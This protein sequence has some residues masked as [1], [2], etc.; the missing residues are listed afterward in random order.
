MKVKFFPCSI[1][2]LSFLVYSGAGV[3]ETVTVPNTFSVGQILESSKL[4][5]NFSELA[6]GINEN[7][8]EVETNTKNITT[9][10]EKVE[11]KVD[12]SNYTLQQKGVEIYDKNKKTVDIGTHTDKSGKI[13]TYNQAGKALIDLE[14]D[15]ENGSGQIVVRDALGRAA[16]RMRSLAH[17]EEDHTHEESASRGLIEVLNTNTEEVA[18]DI[19]M[20]S[21]D[22]GRIATLNTLGNE[23]VVVGAIVGSGS[24]GVHVSDRYG[25]E[26]TQIFARPTN[27]NDPE[28][29]SIGVINVMN[30]RT[31]VVETQTYI[32]GNSIGSSVK[33]FIEPHPL[34]DS[35]NI[36]YAAIEGP[37]AAMYIRGTATLSEGYA[38][39]DL[40]EH[41]YLLASEQGM[42]AKM[43]PRSLDS[44]G[45]ALIDLTPQTLEV[46][47]LNSGKGNYTF[48]YI[49]YAVR[50]RYEDYV[51]VRDK[52]QGG[53]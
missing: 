50:K 31:D 45:L 14:A 18:V 1:L 7:N 42:T 16:L 11:D 40:P 51:V 3:S 17:S 27:K 48:D 22:G 43:T 15:E 32:S 24:G 49:V 4:N 25:R 19:T 52:K 6:S 36:V 37:E 39:I 46:G 47:E 8:K 23:L 20:D 38:K 44:L 53:Y 10:T 30:T 33:N 41:F 21:E 9:L 13:T 5:E 2:F 29:G 35:K 34:D 26:V 28:A 12:N